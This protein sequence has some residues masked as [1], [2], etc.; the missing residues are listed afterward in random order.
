MYILTFK[1]DLEKYFHLLYT[2]LLKGKTM[3]LLIYKHFF[4][5]CYISITRNK[6][7]AKAIYINNCGFNTEQDQ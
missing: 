6:F 3:E 2:F 5:K 4:Y 7:D 1:L